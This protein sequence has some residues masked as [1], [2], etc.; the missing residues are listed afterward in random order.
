M[1][2]EKNQRL[3]SAKETSCINPGD[4]DAKNAPVIERTFPTVMEK[5]R[6][7]TVSVSKF[8]S[9]C[10]DVLHEAR[11]RARK[12]DDTSNNKNNEL[13]KK[14]AFVLRESVLGAEE[15][16]EKERIQFPLTT[17]GE[18][19]SIGQS[20]AKKEGKAMKV[21]GQRNECLENKN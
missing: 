6:G 20:N 1:T 16:K 2:K 18:D 9:E 4:I 13:E 14:R 15:E 8:S 7:R 21:R 10:E 5:K 12:F 11:A 19:F 3:S 17:I